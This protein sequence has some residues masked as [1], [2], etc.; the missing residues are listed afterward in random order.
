MDRAEKARQNFLNGYNCAQSVALAF[1]DLTDIGE[2]SLLKLAS[3]FGGGMGRLREVCGAVTGAFIVLG[4]LKGYSDSKAGQEKT[5]HY[6]TIQN[7]AADFKAENG[8]YICREL[9]SGSFLKA[10]DCDSKFEKGSENAA[11]IDSS[12]EKRKSDGA[13]SAKACKASASVNVRGAFN[14]CDA[15]SEAVIGDVR[16]NYVEIGGIPEKRTDEYYKKRP[17]ADLVYESAKLLEKYLD[18]SADN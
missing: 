10:A 15:S 16:K 4:L 3:S 6:K 9:L 12:F 13:D 7:F 18:L 17:C 8:S 11:N 1:A 5:A 2:D 14:A